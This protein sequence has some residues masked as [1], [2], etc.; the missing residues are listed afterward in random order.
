MAFGSGSGARCRNLKICPELGATLC[1]SIYS[2]TAFVTA[3]A[4]AGGTMY[5]T[6]G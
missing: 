4:E 2:V 3:S 6:S 1:G 5:R